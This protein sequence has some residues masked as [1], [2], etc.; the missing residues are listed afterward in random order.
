M[1]LKTWAHAYIDVGWN[2]FPLQA[3]SKVPHHKLLS[4]TGFVKKNDPG[5]SWAP[6]Q[7]FRV[8]H[9]LVDRWWGLDPEAN[10][11]LVCG[12]ISNVTVIDI[13]IKE[14]TD[15]PD[16]KDAETIRLTICEPT[17]TSIT[18]SGGLH[19]FTRYD[20][21][22]KNSCKRVHPQID[23]KNDGGYIVLPPSVYEDGVAEYQFDRFCPFNDNNVRNMADF[24]INLKEKVI[25]RQ[26]GK[27]GHDDWLRIFQGV[28]K[29]VDGRNECGTQLLG[30][31]LHTLF[32]EF[33]GDT[34]FLPFLWEFMEYWNKKN[35]PPMD[36]RELQA[37]FKSIVSRI[38]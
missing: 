10:I 32:L 2:I 17:L 33:E 34:R 26:E 19:L 5:A 28:R 29:S 13:D 27:M 36:E 23:I 38:L 7:A 35:S 1:D 4:D 16:F 25:G 14:M 15:L 11:G 6:L 37:M 31:C 30:K 24:P 21:D 8:S 9:D 18:G 12:K 20:P 22:I 3:R